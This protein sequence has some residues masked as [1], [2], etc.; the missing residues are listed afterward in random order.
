M[1]NKF[2]KKWPSTQKITLDY[3]GIGISYSF[4]NNGLLAI[5]SIFTI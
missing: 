3:L 2:I 4:T 1:K 5:F